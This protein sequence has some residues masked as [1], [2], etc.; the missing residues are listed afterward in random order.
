MD[1]K[2]VLL[3]GSEGFGLKTKTL[4]NSDFEFKGRMNKNIESLNIWNSFSCLS[5]YFSSNKT[6]ICLS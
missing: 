6:I 4:S 5:S 3:F 1:G 2:N